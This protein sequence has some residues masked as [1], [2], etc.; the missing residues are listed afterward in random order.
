M[1]NMDQRTPSY[2][3]VNSVGKATKAPAQHDE[4]HVPK[5]PSLNRDLV[6][7]EL[8]ETVVLAEGE[9]RTTSFVWFLVAMAA[10][11]GLLFGYDTGVIGGVLVHKDVAADLGRASLSSGAKEILTTATTLG[12]LIG[13]F[14]SGVL[15]DWRGRKFVLGVADVIFIVGAVMQTVSFG[16]GAYWIMAVGRLVIGFAVGFAA[17]IVPLYIGELSPTAIRGRL[18]T[19]NVV[20]I[21]FG[22]VIAYVINLA[23]QHVKSGW[24]GQVALGALPPLIHLGML[25]FLP[26][27]P[28][29]LLRDNRVE[30]TLVILR[31][32]Y[33][34]ATVE[35][36][37]L[38]CRVIGASVRENIGAKAGFIPT[39]KRLHF[40]GCNLR[41]LIIACGLQGIQ[42]LC[43]FNTLT[44]YAPTLFASVGFSNSL[45]IGLVLSCVNFIF[46][47]VALA[48]IDKIGRRRIACWTIPGMAAALVLAAV[49][50]H[51]LTLPT[52]GQLPDNGLGT[53]QRFAPVVLTAIILYVICYAF[54]IGNLP[55]QQGEL[56]E[57]SVRGMGTGISTSCNWGANLVINATFLSLM[58]AITASGAFGLYAGLCALGAVF[59]ICLYP[60]TAG[61]SLEETREVFSDGFGI[62]KAERMRQEKAAALAELRGTAP[63]A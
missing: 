22:Q 11:G 40:I 20:A 23:F 18:V 34:Y 14:G 46:T 38:K 13:G 21:T 58:K 50:F 62:K 19:L 44:Y 17:L 55:W 57:M 2:D 53:D 10:T 41:G 54:G 42:Q 51:F 28:R 61:L 1:S 8:D 30:E 15:A 9:D 24:R 60:E 4:Q 35:Q 43:G 27:S 36:L 37:E 31:K 39:W 49:A 3:S 5:P 6:T 12:A 48:T 45:V 25:F 26:E 52:G 29:Y 59:C 16:H 56:F 47:L 33:P 7:G 63:R 32:I